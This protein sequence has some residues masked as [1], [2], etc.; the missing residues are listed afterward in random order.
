MDLAPTQKIFQDTPVYIA[1]LKFTAEPG[2][3]T[4]AATSH[5]QTQLQQSTDPNQ[6]RETCSTII[7]A[8]NNQP[9]YSNDV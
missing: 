9:A 2:N 3:M 1:V 5:T 7:S 6:A 4:Q 8:Y